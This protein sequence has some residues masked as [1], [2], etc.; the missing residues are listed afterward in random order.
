MDFRDAW[1]HKSEIAHYVGNSPEGPFRFVETLVKDADG[2][3]NSPHDPSVLYLD[4]KYVM[5]FIVHEHNDKGRQ[6]IVMYVV[7]S[8]NGPWKPARGEAASDTDVKTSI[9]RLKLDGCVNSSLDVV[10]IE[11][12][13]G[14]VSDEAY[15]MPITVGDDRC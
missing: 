15:P 1:W 9:C 14:A 7:D 8:P 2:T 12:P 4:G 13:V 3:F 10:Y 11:N 6:H 5:T